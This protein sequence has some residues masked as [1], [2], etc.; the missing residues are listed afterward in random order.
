[1]HN[2]DRYGI[3]VE[4]EDETVDAIFGELYEFSLHGLAHTVDGGNTVTHGN[5]LTNIRY[6]GRIRESLDL[7]LEQIT[8]FGSAYRHDRSV[9]PRLLQ[10]YLHA[11]RLMPA[12]LLLRVSMPFLLN[13]AHRRTHAT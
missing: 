3:L 12:P 8:D 6:G 9:L 10:C 1:T 4:I 5:N 7:L 11:L 13:G 2:D